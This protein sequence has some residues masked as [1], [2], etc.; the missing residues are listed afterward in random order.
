[1]ALATAG[2]LA[3][4]LFAT[5]PAYAAD[6][7]HTIAEVQGT[8]AAT[9]LAG[10]TV[11]VDG[12][13]TG[14]YRT[15]G[16]R[17][18]TIQT[19][20]SGGVD[21]GD[22]ASDGVFVFLGNA[23]APGE[24]GD[25][26][27]VTGRAE[28]FNGQTQI[29]VGATGGT[30]ELITAAVGLPEATPLPDSVI[31]ADREQFESMLVSPEGT[32]RVVSSHTLFSFGELWLT[33]GETLPVKN[34]EQVQPGEEAQAIAAANR[35]ARLLLDDGWSTR[36][37]NAAHP[38]DQPYFTADTVV[39]NG[40][41]VVFPE[42]PYVLGWGFNE[43]RLQPTEPIDSESPAELK[44]TFESTNPRPETAPEVGGDVQI[45]AFNVFN[46]FTTLTQDNSQ[47]RGAA[48]PE[49][50]AIQKSKIVAAITGLDAD[51]VALQEIEN[52]V[53]LGLAPDTAL[54]DLVAGLNEA[55]GADVW[56]Y[57]ATPAALHD[58][59]I[60][61][62]I[63]NAIIYRN[64][65]VTPVGDSL[66]TVDETVWDI[67]REPIAQAFELSTGKV[68]SVVANHFKSKS[69]PSPNPGEPADGQ[70]HFTAER[71]EQAQALLAFTDEVTA[72]A[73]S[74]DVYLIGDFNSYA[75]ED[76]IDVFTEAGW[77]DL[78]PA[79][80]PGQYTYTFDGELGSLD[81]VIASPSAAA[82]VTGVGV[83]NINSPE[84]SDRGYAYG[85]TN[86]GDPFRSSDHDP[87]LVGVSSE[88]V[89]VDI[90][91]VTIND[92]HGRIE[93]DG[94][95]AGAAVLAGA[96]QQVRAENPNTIFAAAG[97]LI[98]ASTF[99]SFIQDDNPT[100]DALNAA[101]LD[102]SAAGNHE[103]DQGWADLRDRVQDRADFE[104]I[105]SNVFLKDSDE[106]ALAPYY[107]E[108]LDGVTVGF[109]GAVTEELESL[110]SPAGIADLEV[111]DVVDSVNAVAADLTDGDDSNGEADVLVLL[112]HEGAA[113]TA[114]GSV[115]DNSVFGQIV[116]G[117]DPG[118][119]AIVSAHTHLA[120]NHV[121]GDT[122]VVSAGQYGQYF[123]Q[124]KLSVDPVTKELLSITNEL[125]PLVTVNPA[126]APPTPLYPAVPEVQAIVDEAKAVA[127]VLGAEKVGDITGDFN[128]ALQPGTDSQ[129]NPT[130]V[131]NRG[132][133]ST[134]GNFVADVQLWAANQDREVD[135]A[136]MNPGGLRADLPFASR[137]ANDPDGN[138]T[139]REAA[140][141]Q[142]FA[143]TLFTLT[144]TGEQV[145]K[146]LEEQWQ[147]AGASRPFLKLGVNSEL[148]YTYDPTA[149]AGARITSITLAGEPLDPAASYDVVANSFLAAGGDNFTTLGQGTNRA[150]S[151]KIDLQSMVDY[152]A[153]N[154]SASPDYAQR[155]VGVV[156]S[157]P[158][159][160]AYAAG[161]T[162][163]LDLS[164]LDFST[165]EPAAGEVTVSLGDTVLGTAPVDRTPVPTTD[166]GGR[167]SVEI[168]IP[169]GVS[170]PQVL[171]V[172]VA[173]TGT[174]V[175]V[176]IVVAEEQPPQQ[177]ISTVTLG[178]PSK[179]L[180]KSGSSLSYTAYV[181]AL[182][183]GNAV[184]T[185]TVYDG[186]KAVGTAELTGDSN[187]ATV[188]ISGLSRGLHL[189]SAR[190]VGTEPYT[191]S[192]SIP[193]PV[194]AW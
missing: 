139:Y 50:F 73:G 98:G 57:V 80:A 39:R 88:V 61:D 126:P 77:T 172:A 133:E 83:W 81:H 94:A 22:G 4:G 45:G 71:V 130:L 169:T 191:D 127:D 141:V 20:G 9:P 161:E 179:F 17:G 93:P 49:Q 96:V 144:L 134:L 43:W 147:P 48:T 181:I 30:V 16:Y 114:I 145:K 152:F 146:V 68:L 25:L 74:D 23:A 58:A 155:A 160:E 54:A 188:K 6:V 150:D 190:Y 64:D 106:H 105:S 28:E 154:G 60:T 151:G 148:E 18:I 137:G 116:Q 85:A 175:S 100:I 180:V 92:F 187:R 70:G 189:L 110:V 65:V 138:V 44:P 87:V 112:V 136:F 42:T 123:G 174:S 1:M 99:T 15:G 156:I 101:G 75:Q 111:R 5:V 183:E 117:V 170:G 95:S 66:T 194:L 122:L 79:K 12:V 185:L 91:I 186:S 36:V 109:I 171:E 8:G 53:K 63:T 67:A 52:S 86:P 89:P 119:A 167:A 168:T 29:N 113:T 132:A 46:Y 118:I 125:K 13:L 78:V 177:P 62:F 56:S 59:A 178:A 69:P 40:D 182:G 157:P 166:E 26:V 140:N 124:M 33:A 149:A 82:T 158:S 84:W 165:T 104:Y 14:D 153:A 97:D 35:A 193:L 47:A 51:I 41:T 2:A 176:P 184:G 3:G 143:N 7:T 159:G 90:D 142:P 135:I 103:F 120:Y 107:T 32:Y 10:Q 76:P 31:G 173:A 115:T 38:N 34:T 121:V 72:A 192:R 21:A 55:A 37:D 129:G 24:T 11:T 102:V 162:V 163:T 164:S 108:T 131:E 27:R 128:R 19:E